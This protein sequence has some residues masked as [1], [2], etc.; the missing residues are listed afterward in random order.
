QYPEAADL[1][2]RRVSSHH[3]IGTIK[4]R[5][6]S[7]Q[8]RK[9]PS[10]GCV[11]CDSL[12]GEYHELDAGWCEEPLDPFQVRIMNGWKKVIESRGW[13]DTWSVCS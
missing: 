9:Y 10:N 13:R 8:G 5:Y 6:S 12:I 3:G 2:S 7:S 1:V 11:H 4:L